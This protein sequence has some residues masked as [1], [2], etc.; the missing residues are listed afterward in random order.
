MRL[1][2]VLCC[3]LISGCVEQPPQE[4][5]TTFPKELNGIVCPGAW[6][7]AEGYIFFPRS[8]GLPGGILV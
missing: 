7:K 3:I 1:I 2:V 6:V 5:E 4:S 8:C